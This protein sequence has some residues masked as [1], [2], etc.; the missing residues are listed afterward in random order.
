LFCGAGGAAK[1]Y[2]RAGF[3]VVGVDIKPQPHYCGDEFYQADAMTYPLDGFDAIH[4]SPP[5]QAYSTVTPEPS[6]FPDLYVATRNR[7]RTA[8]APYA[9]ENVIGAPYQHGITLCGSMFD[10]QEGGEWVQRHRNFE[11]S[12]LIFQ[13]HHQHTASGRALL[14]TG[15]AFISVVRD[16]KRHSRQGPFDL[17][18]RLMGIDWMDR[19]SLVQAIPPAYTEFIGKQLMEHSK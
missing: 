18:C 12:H 19:R 2:Q 16:I 15:H 6:K 8:G 11:T 14:I 1:G 17:A 7:L 3:Y 10:L 13:P 4:A 9:I 5:C